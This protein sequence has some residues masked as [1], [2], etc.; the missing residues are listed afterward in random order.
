MH[1][2]IYGRPWR[3]IPD[4]DTSR[5]LK[6]SNTLAKIGHDASRSLRTGAPCDFYARYQQEHTLEPYLLKM[7]DNHWVM[8]MRYGNEGHE[9]I[10][11]D[12]DRRIIEMMIEWHCKNAPNQLELA[13]I[14]NLVAAK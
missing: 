4:H 6:I 11:P 7:W 1:T 2:D 9:Y 12:I 13:A 8:G 10:S 3:Y 14:D 5:M